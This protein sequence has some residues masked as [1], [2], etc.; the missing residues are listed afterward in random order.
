MQLDNHESNIHSDNS[1]K[2][3]PPPPPPDVFLGRAKSK[4]YSPN[5]SPNRRAKASTQVPPDFNLAEVNKKIAKPEDYNEIQ[6]KAV[7]PMEL[8]RRQKFNGTIYCVLCASY[9]NILVIY[10][11]CSKNSTTNSQY[12]AK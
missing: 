7:D 4:S 9:I 2:M 8:R 10:I 3:K 12:G 1:P 11:R 6:F 5:S